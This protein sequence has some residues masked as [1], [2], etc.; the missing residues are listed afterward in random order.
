MTI[1][2]CPRR[3]QTSVE[4]REYV[5]GSACGIGRYRSK[6]IGHAQ[7]AQTHARP[8]SFNAF[9]ARLRNSPP[10]MPKSNLS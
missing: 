10:C 1:D 2:S 3:T 6:R 9:R 7:H 5:L 4:L 8:N